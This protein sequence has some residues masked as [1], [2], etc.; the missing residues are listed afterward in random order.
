[1]SAHVRNG[2]TI[3]MKKTLEYVSSL[4]F[5]ESEMKPKWDELEG[6]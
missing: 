6:E 1:M 5:M 3:I 4:I 2:T